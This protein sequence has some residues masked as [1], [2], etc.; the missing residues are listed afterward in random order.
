[1]SHVLK[2]KKRAVS[3]PELCPQPPPPPPPP[4]PTTTTTTTTKTTTTTPPPPRAKF[5]SGKKD[6]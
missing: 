6:P 1:M 3:G 4:P 5:E 2:L